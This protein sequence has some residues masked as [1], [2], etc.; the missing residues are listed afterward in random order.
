MGIELR[1]EVTPAQIMEA[2]SG[3]LGD[4]H[5]RSLT[6]SDGYVN[7]NLLATPMTSVAAAFSREY[8]ALNSPL[9]GKIRSVMGEGGYERFQNSMAC[10]DTYRRMV[11]GFLVEP[12]TQEREGDLAELAK[13]HHEELAAIA[14]AY[15]VLSG[16][17][18][19]VKIPRLLSAANGFLTA[20]LVRL[21][22]AGPFAAVK[23][24]HRALVRQQKYWDIGVNGLLKT[25][26]TA[27]AMYHPETRKELFRME[28]LSLNT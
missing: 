27:K 4:L 6:S 19:G 13:R 12:L 17:A 26:I 24:R 14:D 7:P 20:P 11:H 8:S 25:F 28:W 3:N 22:K 21:L 1:L 15:N 9:W 2:Y 23:E 5:L 10:G 16:L 18:S